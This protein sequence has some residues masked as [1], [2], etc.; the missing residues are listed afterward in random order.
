[1][2]VGE[3][4]WCLLWDKGPRAFCEPRV[5]DPVCRHC[6][7]GERSKRLLCGVKACVILEF[8]SDANASSD[9]SS[10]WDALRE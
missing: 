3:Y 6:V 2:P 10:W 5:E 9:N 7:D 4:D 8:M 1:M